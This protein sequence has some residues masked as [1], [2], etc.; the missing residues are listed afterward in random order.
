MALH[1]QAVHGIHVSD[2]ISPSALGCFDESPLGNLLLVALGTLCDGLIAL[3]LGTVTMA[4]GAPF[5]SA[6][7]FHME[8][9]I[10]YRPRLIHVPVAFE[11]GGVL[12]EGLCE[13][14]AGFAGPLLAKSFG[15]VVMIEQDHVPVPI[16]VQHQDPGCT[17]L[18]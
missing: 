3:H 5:V 6:K 12:V 4:F 2:G 15:V 1:T 7:P 13:V 17:Q 8:L 14:M 16:R 11:A 10:E 9:V 18:Q